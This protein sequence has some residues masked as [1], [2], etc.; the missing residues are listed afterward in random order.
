MN[1][2]RLQR[3]AQG[4]IQE[5]PTMKKELSILAF[6][7]M[8]L[9]TSADCFAQ[10]RFEFTPSISVNET[11]DD[12]IFLT[13]DNKTDDFITVV[14]PSI[15]LALV[16]EHTNLQLNYVPSIVRYADR[17]DLNTTRHAANLLFGQDLSQHLRFDLSDSF[18]RSEDPLEDLEDVQSLR[19]T[20]SKYW[21]NSSQASLGYLF[22]TENKISAGYGLNYIENTDVTLDD[23]KVQNP[24]AVLQY[25][26]DVKNGMEVNYRYTKADFSRDDSLVAE[27]D[28]T[29]HTG[30]ARYIRRF[31]PQTRS[32]IQYNYTT[33]DFDGLSE[34]FNVHDGL[35][36][37]VHA[38]SPEYSVEVGAGYFV[39]TSDISENQGGPTYFA[40]LT[41]RFARGSITIGGSGGWSEEYIS[42]D[43]S[44]FTNYYSGSARGE[45][46]V[47]EPVTVYAGA[48][49]RQDKE[50]ITSRTWDTL[51]GNA[52][53][54]WTF[55]RWF[56]LSLDYSY[57]QRD[58]DV[59]TEDYKVNRVALI[60][61][62]GKPF[63]W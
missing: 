56:A 4:F 37:L 52:G 46:Q 57:A 38:F 17:D 25:W 39:R 18:L 55:L 47:L 12:N 45:Y 16:R 19:R 53:L 60:L 61:T 48:S 21:T 9:V 40:S 42:R 15:A 44:G 32:Y 59:N 14:S 13:K 6:L 2:S 27:D 24:F 26:V 28:Y 29:G 3:L 50:E 51:R 30:G 63:L 23:S 5:A 22:G 58:D 7:L 49:Y 43:T 10:N 62:A 54:R 33:R 1:H 41:R 8:V 34:D 36:G 11:Y 31:N 20:R 35:V